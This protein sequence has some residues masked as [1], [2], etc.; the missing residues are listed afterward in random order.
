[1][2][3]LDELEHARDAMILEWEAE[4]D[5]LGL[6]PAVEGFHA[7]L[8]RFRDALIR[9]AR[10][11]ATARRLMAAAVPFSFPE[12]LKDEPDP[13]AAGLQLQL[14]LDVPPERTAA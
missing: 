11:L 5:R 4:G 8:W 6:R 9:D 13:E 1:M 14:A 12:A 10:M 2:S 7:L 3:Y